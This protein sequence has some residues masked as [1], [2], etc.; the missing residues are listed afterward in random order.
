MSNRKF[1]YAW[2]AYILITFAGGAGW[3]L[4]LFKRLYF[5]ELGI[6]TRKEP[7]IALGVLSMIVQ[8]GILAYLYPLFYRGGSPVREGLAFGILMGA[9]MGSS[10]VIAEGA[11][12]QVS[13]LPTWLTVEGIYY[14][15]QFG[16]TG[17][18][19]GLIH[20]RGAPPRG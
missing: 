11:K 7:I 13:S 9:F 20:G 19:I 17:L 3:H 18:A 4:V 16:L 10:A 12:Q 5:E 6:F 2:I 8:G 1:L 15:L 14:L